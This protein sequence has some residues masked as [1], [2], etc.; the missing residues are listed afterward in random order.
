MPDWIVCAAV[1]CVSLARSRLFFLPTMNKTSIIP[2]TGYDWGET[3]YQGIRTE[4]YRG[5]RT[6]DKQ[7]VAIKVLRNRHP[8]FNELVQFRNQYIITRHLSHPNILQPLALER[9]GNG[10]ALVMP[11]D[12]SIAFPKYWERSNR[13]LAEFL[14]IAIQLADAL[15]Y[16][17]AERIVHKDIKPA[18]LLIL[19][20]TKQV[21]L[22]DFSIASLL[23]REAQELKNFNVLEG[24]LAYISPEQTGR[25]NRGIDYRSDFYSLGVTLYE[26]LTGT[27][28]FVSDDPM[29]LVH[30]HISQQP[31]P[32]ARN[33][34][35]GNRVSG[36]RVSG[37]PGISDIVMKLMAKNA[38]DRYQSALGLKF[39]LDNCL[40]QWKETGKIEP[41]ELATRDI[42]DR[43]LIPE[44]LYGREAE[45]TQLLAAFERIA[46]PP[47]SPLSKGGLELANSPEAPLAKGGLEEVANPPESPLAKG[48]PNVANPPKSPLTKGG[49]DVANP[50]SSPSS[51]S[52]PSPPSSPHPTPHTDGGP[53]PHTPLILVAG[54]S[55]IGKTAVVNEVHRPIVRQR[56]YF[57]KGKF[58]QFQRNIPFSAFLQA[59]Q[60]LM[61]QLLGESDAQLLQWQDKILAALGKNGQVIIDVIP[62]LELLIGK[63]PPVAE[64]S[65]SAAQSRFNGLFKNFIQVFTTPEHPLVIFID[66]LQWADSASL[67]LMQLLTAESETGYLLLLGAYRDNE[68]NPVHPFMLTL[69]TIANLGATINTIALLPLK[70][71][72][73]N[74]LVCDTLSCS[75]AVAKPLTEL[76]YQKTKGN[77]FFATQFL[78]GLYED[79]LISFNR[80]VGYWQCDLTKVRQVALTEDVVE[81]MASRL[82][83]LP[84]AT[85]EILKLAA[86][87]G[88]QFDLETLT[89]VSERESMEVAASLWKALQ[90]GLVLPLGETYKFFQGSEAEDKVGVED[91]SVG[92]KFLHDRIQQAAYFLIPDDRKPAIHYRI[93]QLLLQSIPE[94]GQSNR[95]FD[96]IGHINLGKSLLQEGAEIENSARLNLVAA[97]KASSATAYEAAMGYCQIGIELL[98]E[99]AWS[100]RYELMLQLY[101]TLAA[102]QLSSLNY[103]KLSRTTTVALEH[104]T[105][106]IDRAN[107]YQFQIIRY[108]LQGEC[109]KA[110]QTGLLT[111]AE[112]GIEIQG[113]DI[114]AL[115]D[116]ECAAIDE[117]LKDCSPLELLDLPKATDSRIQAIVKLLIVLDPPIYMTGNMELYRFVSFKAVRLSISH[118]NVAESI[119]AYANYGLLCGLIEGQ[120]QRGYEFA[121]LA[122]Q[123]SHGF[124]S[125]AQQCK[126]A[127][128]MGGLI[129]V[130]AKP[131]AGAAAINYEGFL[132]GMEGGEV[133]F[134][135]YNLFANIFN[136]LFEGENLLA[137]AEDIQ[138]YE[139]V[140]EQFQ[141]I[142]LNVALAGARIFVTRLIEERSVSSDTTDKTGDRSMAIAE[143]VIR[144]G[145]QS[146]AQLTLCFYYILR[147]QLA[148]LM[149]E[150][151]E[152]YDYSIA[153]GKIVNSAIG[154][155][156]SSGYYYYGSLILLNLE[157]ARSA[158]SDDRPSEDLDQVSRN[159][160]SLKKWSD[161][162]PENFQ[163]KYLLVEAERSRVLGDRSE[164]IELYDRA[165]ES[166]KENDYL[167]E[168]ALANE[169]AA[170][171]YLDW[172][173]E[174]IAASY[175]EEAYYCYARWGAKAKTEDLERRYA[176]LLAPILNS[177]SGENS[178]ATRSSSITDPPLR[179]SFYHNTSFDLGSAIEAARAISGEIQL[180]KLLSTLMRV[181][182]ENAGAQKGAFI[183]AGEEGLTVA[184]QAFRP[185]P[186]AE[187]EIRV[188]DSFSPIDSNLNLPRQL[189]H[190]AARTGETLVLDRAATDRQFAG[191]PYLSDRQ[192]QSILC[193]PIR[194]AGTSVSENSSEDCDRFVGFLYLENA[195]AAGA[196]TRDRLELLELLSA[197]A[198]ISIE[199]ARLYHRLEEYSHTLEAKVERR[200][201]QLNDKNQHLQSTLEQL[202]RAQLQLIQKEKM[203]SLGQMVAGIAHEINNPINFISGNITYSREYFHTV[204]ELLERYQQEFPHPSA[205][206]AE[207]IEKSELD[208]LKEDMQN[209][210]SSMET[211]S[212]RISNIILSLRN[213]S[214]LDESERKRV[215]I[216]EGLD[217]TLMMVQYR[218]S[219]TNTRKEIKAIEHYG[220]L[221]NVHC[222]PS[223]L[224]Q[225][226]LN[227]LTNAI[228]AL[229]NSSG[230][231]SPEIRL[232]TELMNH[233]TV[234]ISIADNGPGMGENI[235]QKVFDPFFTTKP[236]GKGTGLGLSTSYQ[237]ITEQHG[238][239]LH[240]NSQP[241]VG[242]EFIIEIPVER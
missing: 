18:N 229:S 183:L 235:R 9:Y 207:D 41:F 108:T 68:V 153:A 218:L 117:A 96:T 168:E 135:A 72:D 59:F 158:L 78:K 140:G 190:Y 35:S 118:G 12:G 230:E 127:F 111:L 143:Q 93:G 152:G 43:F 21:K 221:P 198:A 166:A 175:M 171:F 47:K 30:C 22:I 132:A 3:L 45:V 50:P 114:A 38:E 80:D 28:P 215:D 107:I 131:I 7:P 64:L 223:Q 236:V 113:Q 102:A 133:Q 69:E 241:G 20:E 144:Q 106:A 145:E 37:I 1:L 224:N 24:T 187:L 11:D 129:Q 66:D 121:D 97:Q 124:K 214:R 90:E 58:D 67:K 163:H 110:I 177:N 126:A 89:I 185:H 76:V 61:Q 104:M 167:Q 42:T 228:D 81:F 213:F 210:F 36:N 203:S 119:K 100:D 40:K 122:V 164:A 128:L 189:I 16:L 184:V 199:N 86:C 211:G 4:V 27:L 205:A 192:P 188:A 29:E 56:G 154:F 173:K 165:I 146:Q 219:A 120:Y 212:D 237:I 208:F 191:D 94:L 204:L 170:K 115:V 91:I 234:R 84:S 57:I 10:Y 14:T 116:R 139:Q 53:T 65:G 79:E 17:N 162:C 75:Q 141:D 105:D 98:G 112:L 13:S 172:G 156:P 49:L 32:P 71:M 52:P 182:L 73:I 233:Q 181:S 46:N 195:L 88:N 242:T 2:L 238:G 197:Q 23:P 123:L 149:A 239:H 63:Q 92:Y 109:E 134:A 101:L 55:G 202:Q 15:Q 231:T 82:Y 51:P 161:S 33:P 44:K 194:L 179:T 206:L 34:V 148:C 160:E 159:Q 48:E 85:R 157:S 19:P 150:F 240:C 137:I 31:I 176:N 103:E 201:E 186:E 6:D 232:T 222:Y 125:K 83:K 169:L 147:M 77:P 95:L 180:Q 142:L 200:T 5:I 227:I 130:W 26:L 225:V 178:D 62:K 99:A 193:T 196:F 70:K 74:R 151:Q 39:D 138:K 209:I 8:N 220:K 217:N 25:M 174:K 54:F 136:R 60:D 155:T 216:H 226:F 87:I